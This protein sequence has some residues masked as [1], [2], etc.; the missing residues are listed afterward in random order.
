MPFCPLVSS[1]S[2]IKAGIFASRPDHEARSPGGETTLTLIKNVYTHL[3]TLNV[4]QIF[5]TD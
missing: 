3:F 2:G 5:T 1:S 4:I